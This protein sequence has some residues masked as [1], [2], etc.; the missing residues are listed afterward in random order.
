MPRIMIVDDDPAIRDSLRLALG[1]ENPNWVILTA[2]SRAQGIEL[3]RA[4]LDMCQPVDLL[5]TDLVMET[6]QSGI[7]LL[8]EARTV[9]P[10]V[11][12]ILFTAKDH[13]LNPYSAFEYGA[14]GIVEKTMVGAP[15]FLE[16]NNKTR[17]ALRHR[18]LS[19]RINF[20]RRYFDPKVFDSIEQDPS[21]LLIQERLLTI[22]FWDI[23]GFSLLC[24]N[25]TNYPN[26]IA[27]FLRDYFG[28]AANTVFEQGGIVDKFIGDGVMALFGVLSKGTDDGKSDAIAAVLSAIEL[29]TKFEAV[30]ME[31]MPRWAMSARHKIEIG[32]G[33]GIATGRVLVGNV[34]TD[35]RDQF[36]ALGPN[37]NFA[38]RIEARAKSGQILISQPTEARVR[39]TVAVYPA[40][41]I[42]DIKNMPGTFELFEVYPNHVPSGKK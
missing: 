4:Q 18:E 16:L 38:A 39:G 13:S 26:L 3:I 12:A 29:R 41:E 34:G 40:G 6:E 31:W 32:L 24:E 22:C 7:E 14:F 19:Q 9:D 11:M 36:T 1:D 17:A 2:E 37:V 8:K 42:D 23:R 28:V 35:F 15:A 5:L 21:V 33:C 30:L 10:Q 25:L 27:G 20:L